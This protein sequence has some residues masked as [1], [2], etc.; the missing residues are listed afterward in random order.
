MRSW[1]KKS[2]SNQHHEWRLLS[3]KK[4]RLIIDRS[5]KELIRINNAVK[6]K[7]EY[8]HRKFSEDVKFIDMEARNCFQNVS[9]AIMKC[10]IKFNYYSTRDL[11]INEKIADESFPQCNNWEDWSYIIKCHQI[12]YL[13]HLWIDKVTKK[14]IKAKGNLPIEQINMVIENIIL[15]LNEEILVHM[16]QQI[17]RL[18]VLFKDYI[19]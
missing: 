5:I 13:K 2:N 18:D 12:D 6:F 15:F 17:I 1:K 11:L 16:N 9:P 14:L 8:V 19:V 3:T 10:T 4:D 7:Y